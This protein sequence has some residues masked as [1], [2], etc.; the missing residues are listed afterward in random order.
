MLQ[1]K[2]VQRKEIKLFELE[3]IASPQGE[4]IRITKCLTDEGHVEIPPMLE[5]KPVTQI[6]AYAFARSHILSLALPETVTRIGN[7]ALYLCSRLKEFHF[8]DT[9]R[10]IGSGAFTGCHHIQ[11]LRIEF[12]KGEQSVLRDVLMEIPEE[13][14]VEYCAG[15]ERR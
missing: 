10:D 15:S 2:V 7:Y 6:G 1:L 3:C 4:E 8:Y 14:T 13:L 11:K 9:L 12:T 5:G